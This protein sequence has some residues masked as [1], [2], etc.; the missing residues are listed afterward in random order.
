[1]ASERRT[2][3]LMATL[4]ETLAESDP[5]VKERFLKR[6]AWVHEQLHDREGVQL[7]DL[8][9]VAWTK[10]LLERQNIMAASPFKPLYDLYE[11]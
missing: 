2:A 3:M 6:L 9:L 8:Q 11:P 4:V 5:S 7:E 1:M 10:E